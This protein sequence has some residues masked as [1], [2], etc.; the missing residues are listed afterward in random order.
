MRTIEPRLSGERAWAPYRPG[1]ARRAIQLAST[2]TPLVRGSS[3]RARS[4]TGVEQ[5]LAGDISEALASLQA[6]AEASNLPA[7]W[8]DLSVAYHEA[9]LRYDAHHLFADAVTAADRA[10]TLEPKLAEALFNRALMIERLGLHA[11]G[12]RAWLRYLDVDP[13][14]GWAA[15]AQ[16]H[17]G[18]IPFARPYLTELDKQ[19]ELVASD[20]A[21]AA[22]V[23]ARDPFGARGMGIVQ[24]LGRWGVAAAGGDEVSAQRHLAVARA[25]GVEVTRRGDHTL[26]R[27]VATIDAADAPSRAV[28][29]TAHADYRDGILAFIGKRPAD[30][31]PLLRRA[32]AAFERTGSPMIT[33]ALYFA[34]NALY[35]RGHHAEAEQQLEHLLAT[36]SDDYPAYRAFIMWQLGTC[37]RSRANWG[38]AITHYEQSAALFARV[39]ETQNLKIVHC[40]AAFVYDRI[41]DRQSAWNHRV[42]ALQNTRGPTNS[43]LYEKITSAIAEGALNERNWHKAASFLALHADF[44]RR[45]EDERLLAETLFMRAVVRDRLGDDAGVRADLDEAR[46]AA[47]RTKDRGY[48]ASLRITELRTG[49]MLGDTPPERAESLLTEAL[50]F[51][52]TEADPPGLPDLLL[53]RARARRRIGNAAGALEDIERG[54]AEL[55]ANRETLPEGE[56]R[57]GAFYGAEELFHEGIDAAMER[58][59]AGMAFRFAERARARALLDTYGRSPVLDH[60]RLPE[61]TLVV[62]YAALPSR[63]VIFTVDRSGVR[64][65]TVACSREALR[66]EAESFGNALRANRLDRARPLSRHLIDPIA[67]ELAAAATV[68]FVP[69]AATSTVA[70]SALVD[71]N[72]SLLIRNHAVVVAP[73]AAAFA[74]AAER[75]A[76]RVYP[77]NALLISASVATEELDA[78]LKAEEETERIARAYPNPTRIG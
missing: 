13:A 48:V 76:G 15:E 62:E 3:V 40:Q 33:P 57:W 37:H 45:E 31:E 5:L 39:G 46:R 59:D 72:G 78:L 36:T 75:R 10:L 9:A 2:P 17:L 61:R 8:N 1:T 53:E 70:F 51:R 21:V 4:A 32:A 52:T 34:A 49:A 56:I 16:S 69:D 11:D 24:V 18:R 73:S 71:P 14:G 27:A 60:H 38:Q 19:Y 47:A 29:A 26:Q 12:R 66:R 41:G 30:A 6:A 28:L 68:V 67:A 74:A 54:I 42:A 25:L 50:E 43:M 64:A 20:P 63:L 55:E 22:A 44:A 35:E 58:G 23:V 77:T 7:A 65:R